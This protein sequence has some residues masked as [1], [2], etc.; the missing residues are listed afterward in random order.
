MEIQDFLLK[1]VQVGKE[2]FELLEKMI[3]NPEKNIFEKP[4]EAERFL[5]EDIRN[6]SKS[7]GSQMELAKLVGVSPGTVNRWISDRSQ[8]RHQHLVKMA[9]LQE[10]YPR[11]ATVTNS[12]KSSETGVS[13]ENPHP[14][15][16]AYIIKLAR[17]VG[18]QRRLSVMLNVHHV[19]VNKWVKGLSKPRIKLL[20]KMREIE[21]KINNGMII[22]IRKASRKLTAV[23]KEKPRIAKS[24][25]QTTK[26]K[27]MPA[28]MKRKIGRPKRSKKD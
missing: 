13:Y 7:V 2:F 26:K 15:T 4:K 1:I 21:E 3:N 24:V 28:V 8:P 22:P 12:R 16:P 9:Q 5:P 17:G 18:S 6:L 10:K 19:S 25:S 14:I 23:K 27:D 11:V 20:P